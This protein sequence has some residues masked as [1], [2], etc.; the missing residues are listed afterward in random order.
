MQ[1][2]SKLGHN[3]APLFSS[4]AP[5]SVINAFFFQFMRQNSYGMRHFHI[6]VTFLASVSTSTK[7]EVRWVR[8]LVFVIIIG[9]ALFQGE[10]NHDVR[11]PSFTSIP[12]ANH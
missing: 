12:L 10:C 5:F 11:K 9:T 1:G 3:F 7:K 2:S 8:P 6:S 4:Y